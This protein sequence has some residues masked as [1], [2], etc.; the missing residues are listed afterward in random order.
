MPA[1][2]PERRR[3]LAELDAR[4]EQTERTWNRC[5]LDHADQVGALKSTSRTAAALRL[6]DERLSLL[7]QSR[8]VLLA[9][10]DGRRRD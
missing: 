7:R 6:V 4:I 8:Q 10:P 3:A 1:T 5:H 2:H 9:G